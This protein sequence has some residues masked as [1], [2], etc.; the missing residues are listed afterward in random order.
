MMRSLVSS[1]PSTYSNQ[2]EEEETEGDENSQEMIVAA[3]KRS[4]TNSER[5]RAFRARRKKYEDDLVTII[6]SL[7]QEV[8]D[9]GFLRGVRADKVLRSRNSLDGSL[10][11]LAREYFSLFEH[12]MPSIRGV[13]RKRPALLTDGGEVYESRQEEF[14]QCAMDPE[15]QFGGV[16][17]PKALLDQWKRYTSY[18]ESINVE[19]VGIEVSGEEDNPM[20]TVRSDLRVVFSR[21]TFE[22]VFPHVAHNEDLVHKFIGREVVYHGVNRFHFSSNGQIL[23][24]DSDVGFVDALVNAG[25][26]VSDIALLMQQ[27]R[28]ADECRLGD[29]GNNNDRVHELQSDYDEPVEILEDNS[30]VSD[31]VTDADSEIGASSPS[32]NGGNNEFDTEDPRPPERSRFAID[33]LLS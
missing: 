16:L 32:E 30:G 9:L 22:N 4:K 21:A 1:K 8:A 14:L 31:G 23:V 29:E 27:A 20:V 7:R 17:G 24:Y 3:G 6:N 13:G 25:A 11:R 33:F 18:H 5:G 26:T 12:G 15:L 10:V 28:I 2:P 19:V